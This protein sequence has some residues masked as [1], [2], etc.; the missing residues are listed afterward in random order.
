LEK[1]TRA[2]QAQAD[3]VNDTKLVVNISRTI[4][5]EQQV[6]SK[7]LNYAVTPE[8]TPT[9]EIIKLIESASFQLEPEK[10]HEFKSQLKKLIESHKIRVSILSIEERSALQSLQKN[11]DII[12]KTEKRNVVVVQDKKEYIEKVKTLPATPDYRCLAQ[13]P[14]KNIENKVINAV[15]QTRAFECKTRRYISP[16]FSKPPHMYELVKTHK[17][18][19]PIRPIVSGIG[20]PTEKLDR[21]LFPIHNPLEGHTD[22]YEKNSQ[23]FINKI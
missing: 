5:K 12:S 10:L 20:S 3:E 13:N 21:Y 4:L 17:P 15:K 22:T 11:K 19:Y 23:D 14:T 1:K 7:G 2:Y 6:L 8:K 9:F 18:G 16:Q